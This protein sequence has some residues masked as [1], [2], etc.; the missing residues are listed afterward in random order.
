MTFLAAIAAAACG[1]VA[2]MIVRAIVLALL[3]DGPA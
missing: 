3:R 2:P 1:A